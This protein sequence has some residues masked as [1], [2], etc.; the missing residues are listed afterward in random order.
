MDLRE[1]ISE[2]RRKQAEESAKIGRFHDKWKPVDR[3]SMMQQRARP[4]WN[5]GGLRLK[6][7]AAPDGL[8]LGDGFLVVEGG[9]AWTALERS[10][11]T[12]API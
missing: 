11:P 7:P 1:Q 4:K 12:T 3:L 9:G 2:R 8:F 6:D 5:G 10:R